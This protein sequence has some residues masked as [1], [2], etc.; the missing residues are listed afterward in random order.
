MEEG[1]GLEC[2][3]KTFNGHIEHLLMEITPIYSL[4]TSYTLTSS[5]PVSMNFSLGRKH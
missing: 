5:S 2:E 4:S 3:F 1:A